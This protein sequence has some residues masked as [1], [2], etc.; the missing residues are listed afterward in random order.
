MKQ[1]IMYVH[2]YA[3]K[4]PVSNLFFLQ[5]RFER[6]QTGSN[7][8]APEAGLD[9]MAQAALC[10]DEVGWR[11]SA[12]KMILYFTD[13]AFKFAGEGRVSL[14]LSLYLSLSHTHT[15][16]HNTHVHMY[17]RHLFTF[18]FLHSMLVL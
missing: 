11:D 8:D 10:R 13:D 17:V 6:V 2:V 15:H 7:I 3:T 4:L 9:A 18:F 16:T 14:A 1:T 5:T 12:V